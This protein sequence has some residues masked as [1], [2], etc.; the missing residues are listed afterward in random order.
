MDAHSCNV[1]AADSSESLPATP[2]APAIGAMVLQLCKAG[3]DNLR[4]QVLRVLSRDAYSVQELCQILDV[5]QSGMSHHLKILAAAGLVVRRREGN[6]LFYRRNWQAE[7]ASVAELHTAVLNAAEQL[8]LDAGQQRQLEKVVAERAER[9]RAFF[10]EHAGEF[11]EQQEQMVAYSVYG[12]SCAELLRASQP[13]GGRLAVEI[14]PGEGDFLAELAGRYARVIALDNS[15]PMLDKARTAAAG[16]GLDAIEFVLG[17]SRSWRL[18]EGEADCVVANMV[19]HHVPS[20]SDIFN[21][22]QRMLGP[23]GV[24]CL[25]ELCPHD[26]NWAREACGDLWL[27]I[28]QEELSEWALACGLEEGPSV[29]LAQLNGFRVQV[30]QFIKP[31]KK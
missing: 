28:A 5:R 9:S 21:D 27:G 7:H 18:P 24:F 19:L 31:G 4:L 22:V 2:S 25:A 6:S 1:A 16:K 12:P 30:R 17:D 13:E 11:G 10:A 3:A 26:Q 20:P 23:G 15:E 14:G 8:V 29:Y